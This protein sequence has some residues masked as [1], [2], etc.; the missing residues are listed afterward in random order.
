MVVGPGARKTL[1]LSSRSPF[2]VLSRTKTDKYVVKKKSCTAVYN[3][4]VIKVKIFVVGDL[5]FVAIR[6]LVT[7]PY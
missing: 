3:F 4:N 1:R 2:N 5:F 7:I 6:A